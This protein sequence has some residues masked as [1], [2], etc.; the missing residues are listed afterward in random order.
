ATEAE[1][2]Q[3]KAEAERVIALYEKNGVTPNDYDKGVYGLQQITAKLNAHKNALADTK[4]RAQFNGYVQKLFYTE[5]ETVGAGMPVM[6]IISS[7]SPNIEINIPSSEFIRRNKFD[8]F[9]CVAD[10]YPDMV[11]PLELIGIAQKANLNQLYTMRLKV[12]GESNPLL[13]P[14]MAVTVDIRLQSNESD[15]VSIPVSAIFESDSQ[16]AVWVYNENSKTVES[17]IIKIMEIHTDGAVI[18]SEGLNEKET[19][20]AAGVNS[21]HEGET[22]RLLPAVSNTNIGGLL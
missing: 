13:K 10:I 14:G 1:Y 9:S 12:K 17:R 8:S 15:L 7:N 19:V 3:I 2:N 20:V 16:S 5:G 6:S 18:V 21:L 4:L 11:F 22:V